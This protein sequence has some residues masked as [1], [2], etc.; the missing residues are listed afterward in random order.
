MQNRIND[1]NLPAGVGN[2]R[3]GIR[4]HERRAKDD[5]QVVRVHA[6]HVR[7]VHD[8]VQVQRDGAQRRVVGVGEAVDDGVQRVAAD[9]IVVV[10]YFCII[11]VTPCFGMVGWGK[12]RPRKK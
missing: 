6:V 3:A 7:I 2:G 4:A 1:F 11:L 5:G 8:A 10:F 12:R 9:N